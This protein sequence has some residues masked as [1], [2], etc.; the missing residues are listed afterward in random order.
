[1]LRRELILN[2]G[3]CLR[4]DGSVQ[5]AFPT[6][7]TLSQTTIEELKTHKLSGRKAEYIRQIALMESEGTIDLESYR[8]L[9]A[10]KVTKKLTELKGVGNWTAN[11]LLVRALS[12]PDGFPSGDLALQ[13]YMGNLILKESIMSEEDVINYSE[14]WSPYRSWVTT[15]IFADI[16][17]KQNT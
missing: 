6:P 13:K 14:K 17:I 16:R 1:M 9:P 3:E 12:Q 11:W 4:I 2:Y 8:T 15:Y 5:Y 10:D 7:E